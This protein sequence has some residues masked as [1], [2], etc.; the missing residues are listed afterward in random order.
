MKK[1]LIIIL[2]ILSVNSFG[3]QLKFNGE[4]VDTIYIKAHRSVYQFD[5]K[6]TTMGK[7]QILSIA[8][9]PSVNVYQLN[10]YYQDE[11]SRTYKPDTIRLKTKILLNKAEKSISNKDIENLLCSLTENIDPNSLINQ[12]DTTAFLN[13]V[14]EKQIRKIA[15]RYKISWNFKRR[16]STKEENKD[17]FNSCKSLD[18]LKTYLND[19]FDTQEYI[20]VT[21]VSNTIDIWIS[22]NNSKYSFEGKYPN[23]YKQP[24]YNHSDTSQIIAT[25]VLNFEINKSLMAILPPDFL[26]INTIANK[27]LFD[28]YITWYFKRRKMKY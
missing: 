22:T 19:R 14:T 13:Y 16:Y 8:F 15:K 17:F 10:Q 3:Q 20:I 18:T 1:Q 23:P 5:D 25:P 9:N 2:T 28:D 27:A 26:L 24:W 12:I 4:L 11:Y 7:T 6:G 21:D